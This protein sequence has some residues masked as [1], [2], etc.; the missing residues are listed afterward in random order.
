MRLEACG[1]GS[2]V[3][4]LVCAQPYIVL[5]PRLRAHTVPTRAIGSI[6]LRFLYLFTLSLVAECTFL[7][8]KWAGSEQ[9]DHEICVQT[10]SLE[11]L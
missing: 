2:D 9:N 5:S 3:I 4:G 1:L 8:G 6:H 10:G 7:G 11:R